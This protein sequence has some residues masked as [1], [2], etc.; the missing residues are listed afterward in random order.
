MKK[1]TIILIIIILYC[2][3]GI[4]QTVFASDM[5]FSPSLDGYIYRDGA[6]T[7]WAGIRVAAGTQP[8]NS[9]PWTFFQSG[10]SASTWGLMSRGFLIFDTSD[11]PDNATIT[12][13]TLSILASSKDD[14]NSAAP[15]IVITSFNSTTTAS[16]ITDDFQKIGSSR[17]S[18]VDISFNDIS[19]TNNND[20]VLNP[21]GISAISLTGL[22]RFAMTTDKDL[23]NVPPAWVSGARTTVFFG[24]P[25]LTVYYAI[26]AS[27]TMVGVYNGFT[28][29]EIVGTFLLFLTFLAVFSLLFIKLF[30][31]KR[32]K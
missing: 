26:I 17:L 23:D 1:I 24:A 5:T 20:F 9:S 32:H 18:G 10:S 15:A 16:L 27:S 14:P 22:S 6:E 30:F 11:L 21:L 4:Y 25:T 3:I 28:Y 29:G 31:I 19:L 2:G 7:S 13:A 8:D 12:S